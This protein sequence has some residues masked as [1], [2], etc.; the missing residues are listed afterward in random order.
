ME[1]LKIMRLANKYI[2]NKNNKELFEKM[3]DSEF[4][5][6]IKIQ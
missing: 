4:A 5:Q 2:F 3:S 6:S 1:K